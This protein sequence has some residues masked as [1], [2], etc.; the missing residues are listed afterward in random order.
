MSQILTEQ[1]EQERGIEI[2]RVLELKFA[3]DSNG[4]R[5]KPDRYYTTHGNKTAL[6]LF[7]TLE[8]I[9]TKGNL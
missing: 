6:G 9:I 7:R 4:K 8:H 1:Q 3:K 2:A 5:W